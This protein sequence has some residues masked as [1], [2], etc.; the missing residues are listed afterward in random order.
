MPG[1]IVLVAARDLLD[2]C[3]KQLPTVSEV[4]PFADSEPLRALETILDRRPTIVALEQYFA[5]SPRGMAL[6][7][8]IKA[9]A[10][11][12]SVQIVVLSASTHGSRTVH[13][14]EPPPPK[15]P[16]DQRGTRRAPRVRIKKGIDVLVDGNAA[17]LVDL[18]RVGA[19]VMA[20]VSLKPNARVRM[21]FADDELAARVAGV[22]AWARFEIPDRDA[23][24]VY[25]V[26]IEFLEADAA[27]IDQLCDR[28]EA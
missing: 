8:R 6:I 11:M 12:A 23:N 9:D 18:S 17:R 21:T 20:G 5:A 26:G 16:T 27:V 28:W 15:P 4:L 14:W 24:P 2:P 3:R 25:R 10:L 1:C 7:N 13:R 22:V 19:Q